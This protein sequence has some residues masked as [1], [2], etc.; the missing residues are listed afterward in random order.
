M[1]L[2]LTASVVELK[3]DKRVIHKRDRHN[4]TEQ[5][6]RVGEPLLFAV[7]HLFFPIE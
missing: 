2:F 6:Y 3:V 5:C 4:T 7:F 1:S